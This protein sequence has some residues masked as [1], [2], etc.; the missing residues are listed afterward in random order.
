MSVRILVIQEAEAA[1]DDLLQL[2]EAEGYQ[3]H[4]TELRR[5]EGLLFMVPPDL[6]ILNLRHV[7]PET[8]LLCQ[9]ICR[10]TRNLMLPLMLLTESSD[11][12]GLP[13]EPEACLVRPLPIDQIAT[14]INLLARN[15][16]THVLAA[17]GLRLDLDGRRVHSYTGSHHLS[18]KEFRLLETF[19]RR[20]ATVLT[21]RFLMREVWETDFVLD[22]RTLDVHIHW[23]RRKIEPD[24]GRPRYLRTVRGVGY[25]FV[26]TLTDT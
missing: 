7:G 20:P 13:S 6:V 16:R 25:Y 8:R 26:P 17:G 22:T 14:V 11:E 3:V 19:L 23:I 9:E 1:S 5:P 15:S 18:P 21:R 4:S 2:S 12:T 10:Q 24:P